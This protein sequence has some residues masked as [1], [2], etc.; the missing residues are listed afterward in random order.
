MA[1]VASFTGSTYSTANISTAICPFVP[2][3]ALRVDICPLANGTGLKAKISEDGGQTWSSEVTVASSLTGAAVFWPA[4]WNRQGIIR[5]WKD[6]ES[7]S[8]KCLNWPAWVS[9]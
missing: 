2:N 5:V 3:G 8:Y 1:V 4:E 6:D 7:A 9:N